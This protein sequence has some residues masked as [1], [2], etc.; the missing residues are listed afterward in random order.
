MIKKSRAPAPAIPIPSAQI[1]LLT[2]FLVLPI[3][4]SVS[5]DNMLCSVSWYLN[6]RYLL[7]FY[8][9]RWGFSSS[10]LLPVHLLHLLLGIFISY[11]NFKFNINSFICKHYIFV[12]SLLADLDSP[13][14][15]R[16]FEEH[17][18]MPED[19]QIAFAF[20][21]IIKFIEIKLI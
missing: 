7:T 3:V 14:S 18:Q 8:F 13:F 1:Q 9:E 6:L 17:H 21:K 16:I 15:R 11:N 5:L 12:L 19:V 4:A 20:K 10:V 2:L